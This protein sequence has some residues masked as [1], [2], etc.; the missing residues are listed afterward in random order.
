MNLAL[1]IGRFPP[2]VVGGAELQAE[3]WARALARRHRVTV[4]TRAL[5]GRAAREVRDGFT[6]L[7]LPASR[8][9]FW[10]TYADLRAVERATL[11]IEPRPDAVL[12]FQTFISGLAGVRLARHGIPAIVWI[13]GEDEYRL[14]RTLRRRLVSPY[15]WRRARGVLVQT[16]TARRELL[17]ELAR[18]VPSLGPFLEPR[19]RVVPNGID[20][21]SA[22][23]DPGSGVLGVGRLIENKAWDVLIDAVARGGPVLTL[24]GDGPERA[25]LE[26][27]ARAAGAT[28]RFEGAV[29]RDR[30]D[31]L[32][33]AAKCVVLVARRGE[34]LPNALL[35]AM[36]HGRPVI[37]TNVGGIADLVKDGVNG[38]LV[39]AGD[40]IALRAAIE[41]IETDPQRGV[42]LGA[43]ARRTAERFSWERVEPMLEAVLADWV[44]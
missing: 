18:H 21:P 43:E 10:R 8:I 11:T 13:R 35:E 14:G 31:E 34:G 40:A 27:R 17:A 16:E 4:V 36:A 29:K 30:L 42:R 37:A 15:V 7:R 23:E 9:P 19:L 26:A 3:A 38:C 2:G 39:P 28:V 6:V 32:Y 41:R 22:T 20:L 44:R 5:D 1:L 33:A 24:A 12:C 25:A